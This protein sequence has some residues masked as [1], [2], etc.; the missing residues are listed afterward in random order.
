MKYIDFVTDKDRQ[1]GLDY[2]KTVVVLRRQYISL[3]TP[4]IREKEHKALLGREYE[5]RRGLMLYIRDYKKARER[6]DIPRNRLLCE[7][8]TLQYFEDYI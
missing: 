8:S 5:I 4:T 3:V 1:C 7:F 6:L 2:S